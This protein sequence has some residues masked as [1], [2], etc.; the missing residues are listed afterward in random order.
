MIRHFASTNRRA[1]QRVHLSR[2]T[3]VLILAA[4]AI[5]ISSACSTIAHAADWPTWRADA[6][7]SASTNE[8]L[9]SELH[10]QWSR[11]L[12]KLTSAWAEDVRLQ[13]D[14]IYHPIVVNK[15]MY[16]SSSRNDSLSAY[17]TDTGELKWRFFADGPIRFAPVIHKDR[18]YFGA[19]DGHFYCLNLAD[20]S[21]RWKHRVAPSPRLALG[22]ERLTSVWPMRGGPVLVGSTIYFTVGVWPFEGTTLQEFDT[23]TEQPQFVV[24]T[25]PNLSPQGYLTASENRLVIPCGRADVYCI[26]RSTGKRIRPSYSAKGKTDYHAM[27][28][29]S[30]LLHGNKVIH[31]KSNRSAKFEAH[32]PVI[33]G[34]FAY[35]VSKG[36]AVAHDLG[37]GSKI[38]KK[39]HRGNN[40]ALP[41]PP[42]VWKLS[43][44]SV[45]AIEVQAGN[46][47]YARDDKSKSI[48]AIDIP[49]AA[50]KDT[51]ATPKVSWK[52]T[53]KQTPAEMLVADGKLFVVTKEGTIQCY[54]PT[55]VAAKTYLQN[56]TAL[57]TAENDKWQKTAQAA[58]A[59]LQNNKN[60]TTTDDNGYCLAFG[61]GTGGFI[62][63]ILKQSNLRIIVFDPDAT[64]INAFRKRLDK[65]GLYGTRVVALHGD[66]LTMTLPPYLASLVISENLHLS[67]TNKKL[68]AAI[69]KQVFHT[70]RPYG[71]VACL[72]TNSADHKTLMQT[73]QAR[74][75]SN[76]HFARKS[77]L[78]ILQRVGAL[79]DSANWTHEWGDAANTLMSK[80]KLV[81][82]PFGVLWYGG[83]ASDGSMFYDRHQWGP[84]VAVIEGRMFIQGPEIFSAVDVYTG[85]M[86]WQIKLPKETSP[87]RRAN[88]TPTGSHFV[89]VEDSVYLATSNQC[90]RLDPATGKQ[91]GIFTLPV[92]GE[93]WG[94]IRIAK[95][96][97]LVTTFA[98]EKADAKEPKDSRTKPK[99]SPY[100]PKRLVALDRHTGKMNWQYESDL[101]IPMV[102]VG[103]NKVFCYEALL[104]GLYKGAD[105]QRVKGIPKA[106]PYLYI[107]AFDAETGKEIWKESGVRIATWFAYSEDHDVLLA[108][109]KSGI[110]A[111]KGKSGQE[112]WIKESSGLG[113]KGHP[114]NYW[115]KVIIWKDRILD[116]RGPG[117]SYSLLTGKPTTRIHP[118]T[119]EAEQW[120]FTKSGHHC[121]YAIASEHLMTF[122]A[123]SAGYCDL[124]SGGTSRLEGFRPGCRNS[125]IPANGVLNAP[126]FG[127]G[128]ICS[129]SIFTSLA[130]VY[131]PD[132]DMWTY[133]AHAPTNGIIKRLGI[134][135][136]APGDRHDESGTMWMDYP[137]TKRSALD[138]PVEVVTESPQW[139]RLHSGRLEGDGLKWVAASGA[140]GV[141]SIT[142]PTSYGKSVSQTDKTAKRTY[143]IRV[144]FTEPA[145]IKSGEN[146][147]D[148]TIQGKPVLK[149]FDVVNEAS[150]NRK[151]LVKEFKGIE[152]QGSIKVI[153]TPTKGDTL[154]SG[155]E[156]HAQ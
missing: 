96:Q 18:I 59:T 90:V 29:G 150:G 76:G 34:R 31:V 30:W 24:T 71:G 77:D 125:L 25:L 154:I 44:T 144:H 108:S 134:N 33:S 98:Q 65:A 2:S 28:P 133:S 40:V 152:T 105:K 47:L 135:F 8:Q 155:I 5:T 52:K 85:R 87:G 11:P 128:C 99:A 129:Y 17:A 126:N 141:R 106:E 69:T 21:L 82:A 12:G 116:Q 73:V 109:N 131:V 156:V 56:D 142:L 57:T 26:D 122:R 146:V 7:R 88:W 95:K 110:T 37:E 41:I 113:F 36:Q 10:L 70:L 45:T 16:V 104:T 79:K 107:K 145:D 67:D 78:S 63:N 53:L 54:G 86:L 72:A 101:A 43:K 91:L 39:V 58:L 74:K 118:I 60:A 117:K 22:S 50:T 115:D 32:R 143:T 38:E 100:K 140:R 111:F 46:R 102:A 92:K 27:S 94:R 80:D 132:S 147:F 15:T 68:N 49:N 137:G 13:F 19:D 55:K 153:L 97:L 64:K 114:E 75:L 130:L 20:A 119:G 35:F 138:V 124:A 127:Y 93:K 81:K 136:G 84:S 139:F 83:P 3:P 112:M 121:N 9:P 6:G 4:I 89:V 123:A 42:Q 51:P 62:E 61:I 149:N 103:G 66:P 48:F 151:T 14:A 1:L 148:V 120:Q 23:E